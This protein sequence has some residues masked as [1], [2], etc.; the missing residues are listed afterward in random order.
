M[1]RSIAQGGDPQA[2]AEAIVRVAASKSPKLRTAWVRDAVWVPRLKAIVPG[3]MFSAR[4]A[5]VSVCN[6]GVHDE[7]H[8]SQRRPARRQLCRCRRRRATRHLAGRG[9]DR[10]TLDPARP[11]DRLLPG[12]LRVLDQ[13]PGLCRIDDAGRE[14]VESIIG[15]DLAIYL[16]PITF[17]GYSS[18]LKKAIDRS[19]GLI[20]PFFTRI[21]G[22]VHHHA[23]Y[24]R[25]PSL[26]GVGVLPAPHPAQEQIFDTLVGRNAINMHVPRHSSVVLYRSQARPWPRSLARH[27]ERCR[28][29]TRMTSPKTA[30]LLIGSP[31]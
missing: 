14:V 31:S 30:L 28:E 27:I 29:G 2:V 20:S 17:G 3:S 19:I 13:D 22:E 12:L 18:E 9:L 7:S 6:G 23:R 26:F 4:C 10:H 25:Y 24:D 8:P 11:E 15:G 5:S 16:T 21:D 1:H